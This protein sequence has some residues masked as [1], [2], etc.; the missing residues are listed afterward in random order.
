[1]VLPEAVETTRLHRVIGLTGDR[2]ALVTTRPCPPPHTTSAAG[3][4]GGGQ[5]PM[6]REGSRAHHGVRCLEARPECRRRLLEV[7]C[8]P[9]ERGVLYR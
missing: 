5:V 7:L 9:L 1:M 4:I 2:T 8:Q 6:P 3:R